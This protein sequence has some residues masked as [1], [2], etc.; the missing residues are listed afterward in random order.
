MPG[1]NGFDCC[2]EL[3]SNQQTK[4]FPV[5]LIG[6]KTFADDSAI[7]RVAGVDAYLPNLWIGISSSVSGIFS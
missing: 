3:K 5:V 7:A 6:A 1:I 4:A 2:R